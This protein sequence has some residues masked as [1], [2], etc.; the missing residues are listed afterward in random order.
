M[1][2]V[3]EITTVNSHGHSNCR[4]RETLAKLF[5]RLLNLVYHCFDRIVTSGDLLAHRQENRVDF[6][7]Y[8]RRVKS[9]RSLFMTPIEDYNY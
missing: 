3:S 9:S 2:R 5:G 6:F 1:V 8:N 4:G 7:R